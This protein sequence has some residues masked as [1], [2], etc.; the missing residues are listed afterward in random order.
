MI[1]HSKHSPDFEIEIDGEPIPPAL[2]GCITS[3]NYQNGLEG[4][5]RVEVG[6]AN[7]YL[8]WLDHPLLQIDNKF[9]LSLGYSNA[10]LEKVFVGEITG[11]N[12]SFPN[13]GMP[14]LTIV[15]H[16]FMQRLTVGT[17]DRDFGIR[18]PHFGIVPVPDL[19]VVSMISATNLLV[20]YPDLIGSAISVLLF[21]MEMYSASNPKE[22]EK[23]I[24]RQ[25]SQSD[26]DFLTKVAKENGWEMY[27]DHS[28]SPQGYTMRFK[29]M[30]PAFTPDVTLQWGSSLMEFSPRLTTVGQVAGVATRIWVSALQTELTLVL[31]WD[32]DRKSFDLDVY[33]GLGSFDVLAGKKSKSVLK[34]DAIGPALA[35]RK[36]L[37]ELLPR[38]NNRLTGSGRCLA[39]LQL[40]AGKVIELHNLGREFSGFYRITSTTF[41]LD[42]GGF[43]TSFDVRKEIW[44]DDNFAELL[45]M[46]V[47]TALRAEAAAISPIRNRGI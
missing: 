24:R 11:V 9:E 35:P 7:A 30:G 32:Y 3:I 33:P 22:V 43:Y 27:I 31:S 14:T 25:E 12:A 8:R 40:R 13:G 19:G 23:L 10:P 46:P 44:F 15:A 42:S 17:K 18:I 16:D 36:I 41:S 6:I 37:S 28:E 39:D 45:K 47:K 2:R 21:A 26:F 5:D 29:F 1:P 34:I 38:L 20:P 4:A